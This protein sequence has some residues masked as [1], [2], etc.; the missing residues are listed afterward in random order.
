[1][2]EA[3]RRGLSASYGSRP[4]AGNRKKE[5]Y[6]PRLRGTR[7]GSVGYGCCEAWASIY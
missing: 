1:M 4:L 6:K 3:Q 7:S 5:T 2:T